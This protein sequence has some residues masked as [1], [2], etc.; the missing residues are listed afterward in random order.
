MATNRLSIWSHFQQIFYQVALCNED[1][2]KADAKEGVV[3]AAA[4]KTVE[5]A[6]E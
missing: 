2:T 5:K 3:E 6:T 1:E 4:E